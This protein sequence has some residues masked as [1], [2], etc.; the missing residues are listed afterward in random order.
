MND[1]TH[2]QPKA[3]GPTFQKEELI[4]LALQDVAVLES[5]HAG[6]G[7]S[8]KRRGGVGAFMM[9][10]RKWD[11][12]ENITRAF[13]WDIFS[14]ASSDGEADGE[15]VLDDIADLRRYLL[16]IEQEV[17]NRQFVDPM[18]ANALREIRRQT[19]V[20]ADEDET[21]SMNEHAASLRSQ[22]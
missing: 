14:A 17:I 13:A 7:D 16:L 9:A 15:G 19:F 12:I 2:E 18:S 6:Y 3:T 1:E 21:A 8:W 4:A 11:R 22:R 10:A 20:Q 5:K